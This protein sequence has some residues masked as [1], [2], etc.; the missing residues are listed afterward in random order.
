MLLKTLHL[1]LHLFFNVSFE[2]IQPILQHQRV[3]RNLET[4]NRN[5]A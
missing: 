4:S 3:D 2:L 1:L 5:T